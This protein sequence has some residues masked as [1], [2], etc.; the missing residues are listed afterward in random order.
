MER[1][2]TCPVCGRNHNAVAELYECVE[3]HRND[4]IECAKKQ[5]EAQAQSIIKRNRELYNELMDNCTKLKELGYNAVT[6]YSIS[7]LREVLIREPKVEKPKSRFLG[8]EDSLNSVK[9]KTENKEKELFSKE[10]IQKLD[11]FISAL[12]EPFI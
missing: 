1:K 3:K 6:S 10:D 11:D 9:T 8:H 7:P 5:K 12:I 4:E 2:Y